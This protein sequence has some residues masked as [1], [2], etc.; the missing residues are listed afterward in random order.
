MDV[1]PL[2][3]RARPVWTGLAG[4]PIGFPT[5]HV[6]VAASANSSMCPPGWVGIVA[7][8]D[9]AICTVPTDDLVDVVTR[10]CHT[11]PVEI[12]STAYVLRVGT[13]VVAAAGTG[14]DGWPTSAC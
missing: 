1:D 14:R 10:A 11:L 13:A 7:L 9:A 3:D 8:G 6:A 5:R 12:T 2:L 4:T